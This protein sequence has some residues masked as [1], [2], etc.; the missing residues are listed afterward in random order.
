LELRIPNREP[1]S[2]ERGFEIEDAE[3]L[4]PVLGHGV[5][6]PNDCD[7]PKRKR[8]GKGFDDEVMSERMMAFRAF[9][10]RNHA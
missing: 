7:M 1:A 6:V 10:R 5:L 4:H 8:L 3:H 2:F 9:R